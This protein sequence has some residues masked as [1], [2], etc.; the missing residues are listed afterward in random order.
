M[1]IDRQKVISGMDACTDCRDCEE[2]PYG[3][4]HDWQVD[5]MYALINDMAEMIDELRKQESQEPRVMTYDELTTFDGAFLNES[6]AISQLE[7]VFFLDIDTNSDALWVEN[8]DG[9]RYIVYR[10]DYGTYTRC[11][12]ARPTEAQRKAVEW[13]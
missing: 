7:W 3:A 5:C 13:G 2:C 1:S 9:E 10:E 4:E 11:W 6:S 8:F 12:T